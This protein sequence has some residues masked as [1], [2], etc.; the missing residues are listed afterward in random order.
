MFST[1]LRKNEK[2][3]VTRKVLDALEGRK[4][5][6][7]LDQSELAS[8]NGEF[9]AGHV[10]FYESLSDDVK[11]VGLELGIAL[12]LPKRAD[13]GDIRNPD[14]KKWTKFYDKASIDLIG[15]ICR[16]DIERFGYTYQNETMPLFCK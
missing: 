8:V 16:N 3:P 5:K 2:Q 9:M 15:N 6:S 13:K 1:Y 11:R 14:S 12:D 7:R 4:R 10:I